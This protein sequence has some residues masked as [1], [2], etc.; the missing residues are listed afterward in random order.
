M[1]AIDG[2]CYSVVKNFQTIQPVVFGS[3]NP[4]PASSFVANA[5]RIDYKI[6]IDLAVAEGVR[7]VLMSSQH[8]AYLLPVAFCGISKVAKFKMERECPVESATE[9]QEKDLYCTTFLQFAAAFF[10]ND[11]LNKR[12]SFQ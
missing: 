2:Y 4:K 8:R 1:S 12:Y 7:D 9:K 10:G 3:G 5:K 6:S 11:S